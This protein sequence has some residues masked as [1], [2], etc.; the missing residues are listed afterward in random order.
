MKTELRI[1]RTFSLGNYQNIRV[2]AAIDE[3]PLEQF[4][5]KEVRDALI[6]FILVNIE[7]IFMQYVDMRQRLSNLPYD[8]IARILNEQYEKTNLD[9]IKFLVDNGG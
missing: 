2:T 3:I 9:V 5:R 1:E 6:E 4:T 8:E 7:R